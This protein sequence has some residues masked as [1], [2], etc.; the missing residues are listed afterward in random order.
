MKLEGSV[1]SVDCCWLNEVR[2][3]KTEMWKG[4]GANELR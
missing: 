4:S 3:M 2:I 1:S